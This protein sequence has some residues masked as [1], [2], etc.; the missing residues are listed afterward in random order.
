MDEKVNS[1]PWRRGLIG[2]DR[3]GLDKNL[4]MRQVRAEKKTGAV[5]WVDL[6]RELR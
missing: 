1:I 4:E 6:E 3:A 5:S 2:E